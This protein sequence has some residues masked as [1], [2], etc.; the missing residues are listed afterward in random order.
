MVCATVSGEGNDGYLSVGGWRTPGLRASCPAVAVQAVANLPDA[1]L[2]FIPAK[3][4]L[5]EWRI[6]YLPGRVCGTVN[7]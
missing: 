1:V 4:R 7:R 3:F 6:I 5:W 2:F